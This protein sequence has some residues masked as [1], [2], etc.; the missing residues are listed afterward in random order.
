MAKKNILHKQYDISNNKIEIGVDEVG[1]GPLFGRVYSGA[2]ILP[3]SES[4]KYELLKDSKKFS[5]KK[6]LKEVAEY[7]KENVPNYAT[8]YIDENEIDKINILN[9]SHKAMHNA[10]KSVLD[11]LDS[12]NSDNS[13]LL[14]DGKYFKPYTYFNNTELKQVNH[15]TIEGG[16]NIYCSI[17][18]A[19]ILAKVD[20]DQ[21]IEDL[22]KEYPKLQEYYMLNNNK[23]YGT[24]QH[25][26]GI[27]KYG[28]SPWHRKS[29]STCKN[30]SINP[31]EF[32]K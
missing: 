2:V 9:A 32:Y 3:K 12:N 23:G 29:F 8:S 27:K 24:Q 13:L 7:L 11:N 30:V 14:I 28:I 25:I 26:N 17:A 1:R 22:C 10:I 4:F 20:H 21:Y 6:K 31:P 19:S 16:D 5:S 15:V 18:A